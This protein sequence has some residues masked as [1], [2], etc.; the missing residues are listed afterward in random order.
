MNTCTKTITITITEFTIP[1]YSPIADL[2]LPPTVR[3]LLQQNYTELKDKLRA[4]AQDELVHNQTYNLNST[5]YRN[6]YIAW[7]KITPERLDG[8]FD[9]LNGSNNKVKFEDKIYSYNEKEYTLQGIALYKNRLQALPN[10]SVWHLLR[11]YLLNDQ[12]VITNNLSSLFDSEDLLQQTDLRQIAD[13][14]QQLCPDLDIKQQLAS[15][16]LFSFTLPA[17]TAYIPGKEESV[18]PFFAENI[19]YLDAEIGFSPTETEVK[20][21]YQLPKVIKILSL[22]PA[23]PARYIPYFKHV[24]LGEKIRSRHL[25]QQILSPIPNIQLDAE[26]ALGSTKPEIRIAAA[27]WLAEL[28]Y[29]SSIICL[30]KALA[31]ETKEHVSATILGA[32]QVLGADIDHYLAPNVLFDEAKKGLKAKKP[33]SIAWLNP[34]TIPVLQWRDG[35]IIHVDIVHWW[36]ILAVKL[37]QPSSHPLL[38][39]YINLLDPDSQ[40]KLGLFILQLFI[41]KDTLRE[42]NSFDYIGSAINAKGMLALIYGIDAYQ[43]IKIIK[44]YMKMHTAKRAEISAILEAIGSIHHP[45]IIQF[46]LGIAKRYQSNVICKK[47][48]LL[49]QQI[50]EF[51]DITQEELAERTV[52]NADLTEHGTLVF[53]YGDRIFT[54]T[55]TNN[56]ELILKN[57]EGKVIKT[58]PELQ[59]AGNDE[60]AKSYQQQFSLSKKEIKQVV[61]TQTMRLYEMMC[62]E[63]MWQYKDWLNYLY[64]HPIMNKIIQR[65]I[66]LEV[67]VDKNIITSFRPTE[68]GSLININDDEILLNPSNY[69][70]LAHSVHLPVE[71][72]DKWVNH[73]TDY[74]IKPLFNQFSPIPTIGQIKD[75]CIV[76]HE[77][78]TIDSLSLRNTLS[79]RGYYPVDEWNYISGF[80][81]TFKTLNIQVCIDCM[82]YYKMI[83]QNLSVVLEDLRFVKQSGIIKKIIDIADVPAIILA[84][85]YADYNALAVK[86]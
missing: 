84:E 38:T 47:A 83:N 20:N 35:A 25:A 86:K 3:D 72:G 13:I 10:L 76:D 31:I 33:I 65:L 11:A 21:E 64:Q 45:V 30:E 7:Q 34:D 6:Y 85:C 75:K 73:F 9:Y 69:I 19:H 12:T 52:P 54:A 26:A 36:I 59:I 55:L 37:K 5:L 77:G 63:K 60:L 62:V 23:L 40:Q 81:K 46:L 68:D 44:Y 74:N 1:S 79:A 8:I 28:G 39:I 27:K 57:A 16:F 80:I 32:L 43:A 15:V 2:S 17:F 53:D 56:L 24:A 14:L 78:T 66:W 71:L 61:N 4:L 50:A 58:L 82:G 18:W 42:P 29:Q 22:F 48:K 51:Y 49:V 70:L 41:A 67:D